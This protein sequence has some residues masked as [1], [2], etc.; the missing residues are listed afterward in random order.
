MERWQP[1][2]QRSFSA[3]QIVTTIESPRQKP[4]AASGVLFLLKKIPTLESI[5]SSG[6]T[7]IISIIVNGSYTCITPITANGS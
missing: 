7:H 4:N 1:F 3:A 5:L 2:T 6:C